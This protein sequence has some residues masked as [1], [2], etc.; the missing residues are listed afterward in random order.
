[1]NTKNLMDLID[2]SEQTKLF[3]R[4]DAI[5]AGVYAGFAMG[6]L[7]MVLA[8]MAKT[9]GAQGTAPSV[10]D[11]L[12]F[13]LKLEYLEAE[14]YNIA[15]GANSTSFPTKYAGTNQV[16]TAAHHPPKAVFDE[17]A[18]HENAHVAVL[19]G[20]LGSNAVAKPNFDFTGGHGATDSNGKFNGPFAD[21]FSNP[22]TFMALAQAFEDTGVR[23]YKGGAK[24]LITNIP[25]LETALQIHSIEARH[26]SKVR[27]LRGE[28]GWITGKSNTL[29]AAAQGVYGAGSPPADYPAEDNVTQ[30][31]VNVS[32]LAGVA[33]VNAATEAF[34]EPLD[35][36]TVLAIAGLFIY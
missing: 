29:P 27:R 3:A 28:K 5:R 22:A 16:F 21:V 35:T 26:A 2:P 17:I 8:A 13:A 19:K 23:A 6:S 25:A 1:M 34:D 36:G 9:A 4:R 18:S 33:G 15:T 12:N 31:G 32:T 7:P 24:Y 11:V 14:F 10:T 20:A 30:A